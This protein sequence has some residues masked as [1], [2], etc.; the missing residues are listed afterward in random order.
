LKVP[1]LEDRESLRDLLSRWSVRRGQFTLASGRT[2]D[3]YIDGKLTT[4][5]AQA[6]PLVGRL[7]LHKIAENGWTPRAV[8]GLTLGADPIAIAIA[9]QSSQHQTPIDAFIV[10]KAA[11]AHGRQKFIEGVDETQDLPVVIVEDVCTTGDSTAQAVERAQAAG[12]RVLGAICLVD[13]ESGGEE[14]LRDAFGC[15]L[16]RIFTLAEVAPNPVAA[17]T[18]PAGLKY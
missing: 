4:L 1:F 2:S 8:G 13:R 16:D 9:H 10:R 7:F 15:K 14:R 18:Q 6:M 12:M 11:K 17:L 5:R 3:I